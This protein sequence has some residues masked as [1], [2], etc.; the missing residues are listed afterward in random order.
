MRKLLNKPWFVIVVAVGALALVAHVIFSN[1]QKFG[2]PSF[3]A[4][5][6]EVVASEDSPNAQ[7]NSSVAASVANMR[8]P[9]P[10]R[11]PFAVQVKEEAVEKKVEADVVETVH[12]S[13]IWTQNG[14]TL[15]L[16]N[17]Q[18]FQDGDEIGRLKIESAT[19]DGVWLTHWK[20][21]NFISIGGNFT[22]NTPA[23]KFSSSAH[24]L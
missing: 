21:R 13:A 6:A 24:A 5:P 18:I 16:I 1:G 11:D 8:I 3:G 12:L 23:G 14:Q 4:A 19:Q 9:G 15:V 10:F 20:G 2:L 17:E 22:L 7:V